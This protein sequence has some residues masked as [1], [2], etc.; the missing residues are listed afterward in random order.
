MSKARRNH[1][2]EIGARRVPVDV[3]A[4]QCGCKC[5]CCERH[6]GGHLFVLA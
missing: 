1:D 6:V 4:A 5:F 3:A 2:R